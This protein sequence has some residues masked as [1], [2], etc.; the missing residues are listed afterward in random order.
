M[1]GASKEKSQQFENLK[2][3][4]RLGKDPLIYGSS[5][6]D[7]RDLQ[8]NNQPSRSPSSSV[9][10]SRGSENGGEGQTTQPSTGNGSSSKLLCSGS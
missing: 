5:N 9:D 7:L 3:K 1:G 6:F 2:V 8:L 4:R 10:G